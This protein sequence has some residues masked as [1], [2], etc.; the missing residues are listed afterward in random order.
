[1]AWNWAS[2]AWPAA[3]EQGA[4]CGRPEREVR[5]FT[6]VGGPDPG[7]GAGL[8]SAETGRVA[9]WPDG[10]RPRRCVAR[11]LALTAAW[12]LPPVGPVALAVPAVAGCA[13]VAHALPECRFSCF[14]LPSAPD[15]GC[16]RLNAAHCR[17][18]A[19]VAGAVAA[20]L[21]QGVGWAARSCRLPLS[22]SGA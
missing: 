9:A 8:A 21:L 6:P 16:L 13:A 19:P 12:V 15:C 2:G 7:L 3:G 18:F 10:V 5:L 4:P 1:M 22:R 20:V 17:V 14:V 11:W